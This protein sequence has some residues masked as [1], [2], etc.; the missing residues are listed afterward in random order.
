VCSSDLNLK[1]YRRFYQARAF[2][3]FLKLKNESE[4]LAYCSGETAHKNKLPYDIP[5]Y[6]RQTYKDNGWKGIGDWIGSDYV[7]NQWKAFLTFNK[8]RA[9]AR[10]LSL[11]SESEW[12][13]YCRG[14]IKGKPQLPSNIPKAPWVKYR[15][16]GWSGIGDWLGTGRIAASKRAYWTYDKARKFVSVLH[17]KSQSEWIRYLKGA[18]PKLPTKPD[19]IP[20]TPERTYKGKG[21]RGV[22]HWLGTG[23]IADQ[24]KSYRPFEAALKYA[25]SLKLKTGKEWKAFCKSGKP[26]D[27]PA[28]PHNVYKGKGWVSM[29]HWLGTNT[30]APRQRR[31]KLYPPFN[32]ARL[33]A[34]SL[35][36]RTQ[37]QW[38]DYCRGRIKGLP[39]IPANMSKSPASTYAGKGWN[40][41]PDWL[42]K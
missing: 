24:N 27:I 19:Q 29:G 36:L 25:K 22:G 41:F 2:A 9:F 5:K 33:F 35:K 16:A 4:W 11:K 17:L 30:I 7:P 1:R 12:G 39:P 28:G 21:W 34:R 40:G 37:K 31:E 23:R 38:Y 13:A 10:S 32:E 8:A 20:A 42:G 18:F 3:R 14:E 6:P 15:N 26:R